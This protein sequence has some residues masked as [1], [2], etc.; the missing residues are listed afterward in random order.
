MVMYMPIVVGLLA[1]ALQQSDTTVAVRPNARLELENFGGSIVVRTWDR[2]EVRVRA[3]HARRDYIR[4][5]ASAS[6]VHVEAESRLGVAR[7]VDYEI[8][9][10]AAMS[11]DLSGTN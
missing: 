10:P 8:T 9:V 7:S 6:V 1:A 3:S 5:S 11:L 2:N 4:V